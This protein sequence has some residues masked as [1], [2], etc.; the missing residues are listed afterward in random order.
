MQPL[1]LQVMNLVQKKWGLMP[2]T[3]I[4]T[5]NVMLLKIK[6]KNPFMLN[7]CL[8]QFIHDL[9]LDSQTKQLNTFHLRSP[10]IYSTTGSPHFYL[11]VTNSQYDPHSFLTNSLDR[12]PHIPDS[13]SHSSF[14]TTLF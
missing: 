10:E 14:S 1:Y 2:E 12:I 9:R 13:F 3:N 11:S 4:S 6:K 8:Y 7:Y 5:S